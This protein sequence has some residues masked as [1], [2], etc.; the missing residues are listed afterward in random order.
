MNIS[1]QFNKFYH[2]AVLTELFKKANSLKFE[3]WV[4]SE[5]NLPF[6][7]VRGEHYNEMDELK[8]LLKNMNLNY[9]VDEYKKVSTAKIDSK[10]LMQHIEWCIK[11][12][13][14]NGIEFGFIQDEW[15]RLLQSA[16]SYTERIK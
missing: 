14:E 5:T 1:T 7:F 13:G 16:H 4:D 8:Q 9:A 6:I 15:D 11:L 3:L 10:A 12:A 2:S